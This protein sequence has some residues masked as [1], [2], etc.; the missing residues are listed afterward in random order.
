MSPALK[1]RT[2]FL[3]ALLA[4]AALIGTALFFQHGL[5]LEPCPLCIIQ[6]VFVLGLGAVALIATVHGPGL[7]GRRLYGG[8][9]GLVALGG[10]GVAGWHLRLQ[11][12]PE[13]QVPECGPGLDYMLDVYPFFQALEKVFKGS[14]ECAEVVW[15]FL[16]LSIPGWT[17]IG[18]LVFAGYGF[19][20]AFRKP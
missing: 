8:G 3:G 11:N 6:R 9:L 7:L 10:A 14:G 20:L 18:F 1:S 12:L 16:G 15:S 17:L 5:G 4:A 13:D 2:P 19:W